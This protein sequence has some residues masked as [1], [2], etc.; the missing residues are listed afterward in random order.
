[1]SLINSTVTSCFL[2]PMEQMKTE[3][4]ERRSGFNVH[5]PNMVRRL[6]LLDWK[7]E[8]ETSALQILPSTKQIVSDLLANGVQTWP[9]VRNV[10]IYDLRIQWGH[11]MRLSPAPWCI[12]GRRINFETCLRCH[13][14]AAGIDNLSDREWLEPWS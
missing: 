11:L 14:V 4:N 9:E 12:H 5:E 7:R 13:L 2:P 10:N 8:A 3:V 6:W 1:M